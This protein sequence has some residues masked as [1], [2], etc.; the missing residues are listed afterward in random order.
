MYTL[1]KPIKTIA[2]ALA[3]LGILSFATAANVNVKWKDKESYTDLGGPFDDASVANFSKEINNYLD[4]IAPEYIP[5][6]A[7]LELT[8]T[9]V[10]LAGE[11]EPWRVDNDARIVR[12]IYPPRM[13]FN[14]TLKSGKGELI[15]S[16]TANLVDTD[17][18]YNIG[19]RVFGNDQFFYEK[20]M[21]GDWLR[22]DLD[23][24]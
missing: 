1:P 13:T 24:S 23:A 10:D 12:A 14:Y 8:V 17:F 5:D 22:N 18:Q 20:E 21:L 9:D 19:R 16:G 11:V 3:S 2:F 7:T 4:R 6:D 15:T